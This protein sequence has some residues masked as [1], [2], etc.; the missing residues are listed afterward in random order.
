MRCDRARPDIVHLPFALRWA[1][2]ARHGTAPFEHA[3]GKR[4]DDGTCVNRTARPQRI[5]FLT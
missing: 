3:Q 5:I 1:E 2:P 4:Y